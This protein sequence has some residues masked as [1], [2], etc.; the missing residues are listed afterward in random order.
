MELNGPSVAVL[1]RTNVRTAR[2]QEDLFSSVCTPY[3]VKAGEDINA[4]EETYLNLPLG[5]PI[6]V[7]LLPR[8]KGLIICMLSW[9]WNPAGDLCRDLAFGTRH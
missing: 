6:Q 7:K 8:R 3:G 4:V 1:I 2:Q 5:Q 9:R